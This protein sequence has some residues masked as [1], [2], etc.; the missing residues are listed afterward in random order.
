MKTRVE[1]SR[2]VT[3]LVTD[4]SPFLITI[5]GLPVLR[6]FVI[7]DATANT[8]ASDKKHWQCIGTV[9]TG[10]SKNDCRLA[11]SM[12]NLLPHTGLPCSL[13]ASQRSQSVCK[14]PSAS[15]L[16][17]LL[18]PEIWQMASGYAWGHAWGSAV[19]QSP[20]LVSGRALGKP[21]M[22]IKMQLL[23]FFSPSLESAGSQLA[24]GSP[25]I[26]DIA[27]EETFV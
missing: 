23:F 11:S 14:C 9:I 19:V 20:S 4:P 16:S 17:C 7:P 1:L 25:G 5:F 21:D 10:R 12:S 3:R 24:L 8:C 15:V 13:P 26:T 22:M 2:K 6:A 27:K 18:L